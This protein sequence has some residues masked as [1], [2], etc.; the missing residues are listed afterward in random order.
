MTTNRSFVAPAGSSAPILSAAEAEQLA[1]RF[2]A[3]ME[4]LSDLI[5]R[6][7]ELVRLG[8]LAQAG[9]LAAEK[10]DLTR[11]YFADALQLQASNASLKRMMPDKL[12]ALR[13]RHGAF[14]AQ[15]QVNLTVLA[16][17]H[18]ISE[19]IVRGV[20]DEMAR[21]SA[22]QTYGASGR[23]YEPKRNASVSLTVSRV[24]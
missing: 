10:G 9:E 24:L 2:L 22:P 14:R 13:Q 4:D 11:Q 16:T 5:V 20:S 1:T 6:E 19:G 21:K 12:D 7:T 18:A 8:R 23:P 17:A 3:V 15:L